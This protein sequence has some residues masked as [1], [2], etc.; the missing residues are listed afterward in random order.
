MEVQNEVM[1]VQ[2]EVP[3]PVSG[4]FGVHRSVAPTRREDSYSFCPRC[5]VAGV[6]FPAR[7]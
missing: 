1:R 2:V 3:V 7:L 4:G 5:E 6:I